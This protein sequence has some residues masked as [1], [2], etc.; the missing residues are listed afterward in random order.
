MSKEN[1][2]IV[3]RSLEAFNQG[4]IDGALEMY[5]PRAEV[6][7]LLSGTARGHS[8]IRAVI[9]EREK[10]M[11]AVQY[12]LEEV[13]D[14]G[15]T[16]VGVVRATGKGRLSGISEADFPTAPLLA[17]V[18]TLRAGLVIRHQM[19]TTRAEA[20]AAAGLQE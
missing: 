18:W 15:D 9:R 14:A 4:D 8:E 10:A 6:T 12:L 13:V 3:R 11:G 7:T 20:M 1:V 16:V 19:F 5:D 17:I 2:E